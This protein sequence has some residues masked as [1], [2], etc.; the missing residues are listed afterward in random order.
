MFE[1]PF[2]SQRYLNVLKNPH[3]D[4]PSYSHEAMNVYMAAFEL[5]EKGQRLFL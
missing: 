1:F 4:E 5:Q 3:S 2:F